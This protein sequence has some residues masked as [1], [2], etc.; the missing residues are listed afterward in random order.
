MK[1]HLRRIAPSENRAI[2]S[3]ACYRQVQLALENT[4]RNEAHKLTKAP[5]IEVASVTTWIKLQ[6]AAVTSHCRIRYSRLLV[7]QAHGT[8]TSLAAWVTMDLL[9]PHHYTQHKAFHSFCFI[10]K[11][12]LR[13]CQHERVLLFHI[14]RNYSGMLSF[15]CTK[16]LIFWVT[17]PL[18]SLSFFF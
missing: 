16:L 17:F 18:F 11:K 5:S 12:I 4:I 10:L 6:E 15:M 3:Q 2:G 7:Y 1:Y 13:N 14:S 9:P 8:F